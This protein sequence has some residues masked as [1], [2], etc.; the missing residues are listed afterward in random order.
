MYLPLLKEKRKKKK[1]LKSNITE[2]V[3]R[4]SEKKCKETKKCSKI[5]TYIKMLF[6]G[7]AGGGVKFLFCCYL[8]KAKIYRYLI[9]DYKQKSIISI[10]MNLY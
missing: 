8:T 2:R 10:C 3:Q 1:K 4:I 6:L 9:T 7:G 5:R